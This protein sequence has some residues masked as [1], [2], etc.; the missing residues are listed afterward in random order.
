V[1]ERGRQ[2]GIKG[3]GARRAGAP[4]SKGAV[5][6]GCPRGANVK[7]EGRI[8]MARTEKGMRGGRL[9]VAVAALLLVLLANGMLAMTPAHAAGMTMAPETPEVVVT[10]V[11]VVTDDGPLLETMD[12]RIFLL[13]GVTDLEL[14]GLEVVVTGIANQIE[15]G[16]FT[17]DVTGYSV[18]D[19][20]NG[21]SAP[22]ASHL[23]GVDTAYLGR[24]I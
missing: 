8:M 20:D 1:P 18:V 24:R 11:V 6:G 7:D 2:A 23:Y 12:D 16:Y 5:Q 19:E 22:Q 14:D 17:L 15:D 3:A 10:G 4:D 9:F 13:R 21:E